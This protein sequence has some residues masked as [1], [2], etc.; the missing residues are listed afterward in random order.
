MNTKNEILK[1]LKKHQTA[2]G[3][4]L[5]TFLGISR[6]AL[7]KH[8][9]KLINSSSV[10]KK[11]S[12]KSARYEFISSSK[13][14]FYKEL[15]LKKEYQLSSIEEDAVFNDLSFVL[16]FKKRLNE[17]TLNIVRYAFTEILNNAIDHSKSEKCIVEILLDQYNFQFVIRDFGIGVFFS[18]YNKYDLADENAAVGELIKGKTTTMSE[19][20]SGE[21]IFFTS[22][23]ADEM[24]L[25]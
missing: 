2:T 5:C 14:R 8:L 24:Q 19:R 13:K 18:I 17:R 15:S 7:N 25:R 6:Q 21:G 11:G 9:K 22:K 20:H 10:V 4:E 23:S 16:N 3:N 12:T 1:Y